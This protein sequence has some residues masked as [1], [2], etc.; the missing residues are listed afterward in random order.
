MPIIP[1]NLACYACQLG[2]DAAETM[3]WFERALLVGDAREM[4]EMAL[5]DSDLEPVWP[6]IRQRLHG[7]GASA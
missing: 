5:K 3:D 6:L 1:Y 4:L 7:S 2:R